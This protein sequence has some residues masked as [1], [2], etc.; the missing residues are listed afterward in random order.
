MEGVIP[1]FLTSSQNSDVLFFLLPG[2]EL[3]TPPL[4]GMILPGVTRDSVLTLGRE[5]ASGAYTVT[6][7]PE[8]LTVTERP[9]TMMEVREASHSGKLVEMFGAGAYFNPTFDA[10]PWSQL[11]CLSTGTAAVISPVDR[12]GYQ[13][14]DV[15][16]PTGE[17]GMGP[18]SR[19][20][21]TELIGRQT[22]TISSDWSVVI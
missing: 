17:D 7:L 8:N 18:I 11:L 2:Y 19:H 9:V 4:D 22:G 16:I 13:G 6:G 10:G 15:L 1:L 21:W 14:E 20:I 3:V 12:I 5:H